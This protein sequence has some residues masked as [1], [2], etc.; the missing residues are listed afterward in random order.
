MPTRALL[1]F[2]KVYEKFIAKHEINI[3]SSTP[4]KLPFPQHI[5][6]YNG[7]RDE[8][9][10]QILKLSDL[11][12]KPP[13]DLTPCLECTSLMLN[14]NYGHNRALME[15]CRRLEEYALFV[16][17]VRKHLAAGLPLEQ[18][19]S[20][21]V[22]ECIQK[23]ILKDILTAQKAEVVQVVLETFDQEK[24]EKAMKQE[25]YEDGYHD[26]R[27]AGYNAGRTDGYSAGCEE[28]LRQLIA[29][30]MDIREKYGMSE[31]EIISEIMQKYNLTEDEA[32][33]KIAEFR[34]G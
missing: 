23:D 34:A 24:Y 11:F 26:G 25:G 31:N 7:T 9:D 12:E 19:V 30:L 10:R 22:D 17:S 33:K 8:P 20:Q 13:S 16:D 28:G 1:Y 6:F 4:K 15:R 14:I 29:A 27:N 2:A 21:S 5:V 18:A 3:Y 32:V